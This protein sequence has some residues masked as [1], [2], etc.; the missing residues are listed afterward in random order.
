MVEFDATFRFHFD[1]AFLTPANAMLSV[2][3]TNLAEILDSTGKLRNVS[4]QARDWS[5]KIHDAIWKTTVR[6]Q[7]VCS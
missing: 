2:E 1:S 3:L 5:S 6:L 4:Q 7:L